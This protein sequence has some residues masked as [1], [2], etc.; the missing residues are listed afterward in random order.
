MSGRLGA[1]IILFS[2]F[3][4]LNSHA[5]CS[6]EVNQ[7]DPV[8]NMVVKRTIDY[9]VGKLFGQ[10]VY[11]KAQS[12]GEKRYLKIR[13]F[14]YRDLEISD[15]LPLRFIFV[16]ESYLDVQPRKAQ[17]RSKEGNINVVSAMILYDI[18]NEQAKQL[19]EKNVKRV[20]LKT[21][22][23]DPLEI[24]VRERFRNTFSIILQCVT[25]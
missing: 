10:P 1:L 18:S 7:V 12:I 16:D 15:E 22:T 20:E 24:D 2:F 14:M 21:T 6:L 19:I 25:I 23:G 5:Q 4:S 13:Y 11:F 9:S 8:T 3:W 17:N